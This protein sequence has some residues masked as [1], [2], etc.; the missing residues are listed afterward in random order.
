M[1]KENL[2]RLV[3]LL[4]VALA[5]SLPA[6]VYW[7]YSRSAAGQAAGTTVELHARMPEAGGW[8]PANLTAVVGQPLRLRLT[9]D[10]V[11]H[12]FVLGQSAQPSAEV[13]PG[14]VTEVTLTFDHP[15]G[16]AIN[17]QQVVGKAETTLQRLAGEFAVVA[18][19]ALA[20]YFQA[21]GLDNIGPIFVDH[22][23]SFRLLKFLWPKRNLPPQ[24]RRKPPE[25]AF[26]R[27]RRFSGHKGS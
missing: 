17:I 20:I 23:P 21:F 8:T 7:A 18:A 16:L 27:G 1:K 2:A 4:L 5:V 15:G 6:G 19:V 11:V 13:K 26:R 12:G 3:L 22:G 25:P 14:E 10:D 9:S 24:E